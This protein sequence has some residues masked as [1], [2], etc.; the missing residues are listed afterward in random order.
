MWELT[1]GNEV[2]PRS[3]FL[4]RTM[5]NEAI[6]R[7]RIKLQLRMRKI[8]PESFIELTLFFDTGSQS[9]P[10]ETRCQNG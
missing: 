9:T 3:Y 1:R 8:H 5:T 10:F 6:M 4:R 2:K 7:A